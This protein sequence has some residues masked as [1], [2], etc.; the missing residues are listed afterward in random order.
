MPQ[1]HVCCL[2]LLL[3]LQLSLPAQVA[4]GVLLRQ[5][6]TLS[7]AIHDRKQVRAEA[8]EL[9]QL[10]Q[11]LAGAPA[12]AGGPARLL[13]GSSSPHRVPS[14]CPAL[15]GALLE[16]GG[17]EASVTP[18][19]SKASAMPSSPGN[20]S[21][22]ARGVPVLPGGDGD[23]TM[24]TIFERVSLEG[25]S[26]CSCTDDLYILARSRSTGM[27]Q[28][29][30]AH[31]LTLPSVIED[32]GD[33]AEVTPSAEAAARGPSGTACPGPSASAP[34]P[35][36]TAAAPPSRA[37]KLLEEADASSQPSSPVVGLVAD[38]TGDP[39]A[40]GG[41]LPPS[42]DV[43]PE[44]DPEVDP[45]AGTLLAARPL[46]VMAVQRSGMGTSVTALGDQQKAVAAVREAAGAVKHADV[47][48]GG[49]VGCNSC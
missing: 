11:Q 43:D 28:S 34:Q 36:E 44:A 31:T 47:N 9:R 45:S 12:A 19:G 27:R 32:G 42:T 38:V 17:S 5:V 1:L 30:L 16:A 33:G 3:I 20:A 41:P 26:N 23:G 40:D 8:K 29:T 37:L 39:V 22:K 6:D 24:G 14:Q 46:K 35:T 48:P 18:P 15:R 4:Q 21:G 2:L 13:T 49:G 25:E 10:K 7:K